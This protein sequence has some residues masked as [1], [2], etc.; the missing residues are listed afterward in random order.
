MRERNKTG[1]F[2]RNGYTLRQAE[3]NNHLHISDGKGDFYVHAGHKTPIRDEKQAAELIDFYQSIQ[4][5][6]ADGAIEER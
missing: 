4:K 3:S 5:S 2:T 1:E 6:I